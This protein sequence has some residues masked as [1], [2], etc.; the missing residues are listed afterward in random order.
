ML[1]INS[2]YPKVALVGRTNAGKSTLFNRL[3]EKNTA[4]V[5]NEPGT[6]RDTRHGL[7][8]W[9]G[10]YVSIIDTA[11][12]DVESQAEIDLESKKQAQIAIKE[13][14][15][16]LFLVSVKDGILPQDKEIAKIIK[17][18]KKP[19]ILVVNKVD[20]KSE[21][22]KIA[23]F[24]SLGFEDLSA[25][26]AKSGVGTGDLLDYVYD[27]LK[28][29]GKKPLT[30]KKAD[31]LTKLNEIKISILGKPNVGKSSLVNKLIGAPRTIVSPVP[32]TTRESQ[33]IT[34]EYEEKGGNYNLTFI[35][36]AGIIKKRKM[37][38]G[39]QTESIKQS[40][41]SLQKSDLVIFMIDAGEP[42]T[43]QDKNI[44]R[45]IL[46]SNRSLIIVVNKWDLVEDKDEHSDKEYIQ[47]LH[48]QFPYLTWAPIIFTSALTGFKVNR[49][50]Q[51][52]VEIYEKQH[53]PISDEELDEF[54]KYILKRQPPRK[55]KG[56]KRP[57]LRKIRQVNH[58]PL[59]FTV[60]TAPNDTLHF[61]YIR[62]IKNHL[63]DYFKLFGCGIHVRVITPKKKSHTT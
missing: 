2:P 6:T 24:F 63:R 9:Q 22:N 26:S 49:L 18:H 16:V 27:E 61:S 34:L 54:L 10:K 57:Y 50:L 60:H 42:I 30:D 28:K 58:D 52:I 43:T 51:E 37:Q 47:Y 31:D 32:H 55:A 15:I 59:T 29:L 20:K 21:L 53:K 14:D 7:C 48:G 19:T 8:L 45:E 13:A 39:L 46:D 41:N 5:S 35:D 36:T 40:L 1:K 23:E 33:D 4:L 11:G 62:F 38:A 17:K 3:T 25:I 44:T 56:T 12:L